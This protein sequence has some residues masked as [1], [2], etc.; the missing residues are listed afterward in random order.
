MIIPA[1]AAPVAQ[2]IEHLTSNLVAVGSNPAGRVFVFGRDSA[3]WVNVAF[4]VVKRYI[5]RMALSLPFTSY[6]FAPQGRY[7]V[8][9]FA[10][11]WLPFAG[12]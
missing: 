6:S 10:S 12:H 4:C 5:N 1:R 8:A 9:G 2:W 7:F 11:L 3:M